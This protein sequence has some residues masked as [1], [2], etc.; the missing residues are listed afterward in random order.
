M[1]KTLLTFILLLVAALWTQVAAVDYYGLYVGETQVTS[2][3]KSNIRGDGK[4]SY[5]SDNKI[6]TVQ[7]GAT[8]T[9]SSG[10]MGSGIRNDKVDGLMIKFLGE[11]T[12]NTR[13]NCISADK[14][15]RIVCTAGK[16]VTLKST[17]SDGIKSYSA[18]IS[19]E[20]GGSSPAFLT[21]NASRAFAGY[22]S[23]SIIRIGNNCHFDIGATSTSTAAT[24][25]TSF[26]LGNDAVIALP[27]GGKFDTSSQ[28][29]VDAF[30]NTAQVLRIVPKSQL[31]TYS[32]WVGG[33][34]VNNYNKDKIES[35]AIKNGTVAYDAGAKALTITGDIDMNEVNNAS[36]KHAI[37]N[38]G[39]DG[40]TVRWLESGRSI[41]GNG[42][43]AAI[44]AGKNTTIVTPCYS[45]SSVD[46]YDVTIDA[47]K[48]YN[49]FAINGST[50][51]FNNARLKAESIAGYSSETTNKVVFKG[52]KTM[53]ITNQIV[54]L[55]SVTNTS[56][57]R[58]AYPLGVTYNSTNKCLWKDGKSFYG[59]TI[60]GACTEI[61]IY[62]GENYINTIAAFDLLGDGSGDIRYQGNST[63]GTIYM[64]NA[65]FK[66]T[67][68][69]GTAINN[70]GV[71]NLTIDITGENKLT[72]RLMPF[73]TNSN[74]AINTTIK[75]SGTLTLESLSSEAVYVS[76]G[77]ASN[78]TIDDI[79]VNV[80]GTKK[81]IVAKNDNV[82]MT[83]KDA[84]LDVEAPN[85]P[86]DGFH[87][88]E[89]EGC[90]VATPIG[91]Y[92]EN[93]K[94][95]TYDGQEVTSGHVLITDF[96][97]Y[98]ITIGGMPVNEYNADDILGDGK[99]YYNASRQELVLT[100]LKLT[101]SNYDNLSEF[102]IQGG[103][104]NTP[105]DVTIRLDGENKI[106]GEV[107]LKW[108]GGKNVTLTGEGSLSIKAMTNAAIIDGGNLTIQK[109]ANDEQGPTATFASLS[110]EMPAIVG[111]H[112]DEALTIDGSHVEI[113]ATV[114]PLQNFGTVNME[115][116]YLISPKGAVFDDQKHCFVDGNGDP[117]KGQTIIF[118]PE[119]PTDYGFDVAGV[120]VDEMNAD[121]ITGEGIKEGKVSFD[122]TTNTLTLDGVTMSAETGGLNIAEFAG[123]TLTVKLIGENKCENEET[124]FQ[125]NNLTPLEII[126][127]GPGSFDGNISV[128]NANLTVKDGATL[129]KPLQGG[130][131]GE[132]L[133]VDNATLKCDKYT[134]S[135]FASLTLANGMGI[136]EPVRGYY[137]DQMQE[138]EDETGAP[139][140]GYLIRPLTDEELAVRSINAD[141]SART[142]Y[143]V[144][145]QRT[146]KL[147]RGVNVVIDENGR[148]RKQL[149]K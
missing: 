118:R 117:I 131:N 74:N 30:G 29:F 100:D 89:M 127:C 86:I 9:N 39:I 46:D 73:S 44:Y 84:T 28:K 72:G 19:L 135:D 113:S 7:N 82:K 24:G 81:G 134:I 57:V 96:D 59:E 75:G 78:L 83:I 1:R 70:R 56:P 129:L 16:Y 119:A 141:S 133:T 38:S 18:T 52:D 4:F 40:L 148:T 95:Y 147:Q 102:T 67:G 132:T 25:L 88:I 137:N 5:D 55:A 61:P 69:L 146:G 136:I 107:G 103:D 149:V 42:G 23:N 92:C 12:I 41:T 51:T 122:A 48:N 128:K 47:P 139:A 36:N 20:M 101:K 31:T 115:N 116:V 125:V 58:F 90:D 13:M 17:S 32:L 27:S 65:S 108:L 85:I 34:Q 35:P 43:G 140:W 98:G 8:I 109:Y 2:S 15:T 54:N 104:D 126:I 77:A 49:I 145:G 3:N 6:L 114:E 142:I 99:V 130:R 79:T 21:I 80:I 11:A 62:F 110:D 106:E 87:A 123:T 45:T 76:C 71:K 97:K 50:I 60:I 63:T 64:D 112:G 138:L 120:D 66:N 33:V 124:A 121:N 111:L 68:V 10:T 93:G 26:N 37:F 91:G 53:V 94:I 14:T 22:G 105:S 143:N 144:Q